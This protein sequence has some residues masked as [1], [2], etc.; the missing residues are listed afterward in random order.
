MPNNHKRYPKK[1]DGSPSHRK[2]NRPKL[3]YQH[4]RS[5]NSHGGQSKRSDGKRTPVKVV[6]LDD[7]HKLQKAA[8]ATQTKSY[9]DLFLGYW[10]DVGLDKRSALRVFK[11]QL[12]SRLPEEKN[13]MLAMVDDRDSFEALTFSS[14]DNKVCRNLFIRVNCD[15][16]DAILLTH[17][18]DDDEKEMDEQGNFNDKLKDL[19]DDA[20]SLFP[21]IIDKFKPAGK[22]FFVVGNRFTDPVTTCWAM[23]NNHPV[24]NYER[25]GLDPLKDVEDNKKSQP[26]NKALVLGKRMFE[27]LKFFKKFTEADDKIPEDISPKKLIDCSDI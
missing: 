24:L 17:A 8:D 12:K 18:A 11:N 15:W 6:R 10:S 23:T 14:E 25:P 20:D 13:M 7:V 26:H 3:A 27:D 16:Y 22:T 5:Q 19:Y 1:K 21:G 2:T 9:I 4:K